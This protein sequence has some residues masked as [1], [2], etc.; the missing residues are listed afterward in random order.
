LP[1]QIT[2]GVKVEISG[3]HVAVSGPKGELSRSFPE[4]VAVTIVDGKVVVTPRDKTAES[5]AFWG[6][7]RKLISNMVE[8]VSN[9]FTK[10][11]EIS[12]VG[13]KAAVN[14]GLIKLSLGFSHDIYYALPDDVAVVC[15]RPT[16]IAISGCDK[17]KVGQIAAEIRAFKKPEPY[18]GKG[19]KYEGERIRRKE[20]KKK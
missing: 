4:N 9:G 6:L 11:L 19:I 8:G 3:Q 2:D 20:G 5:K 10:K 16:S 14:N 12:G 18:K 17:E 15:E 7:T 13:F 1:V